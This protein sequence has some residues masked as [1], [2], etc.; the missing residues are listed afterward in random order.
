MDVILWTAVGFIMGSI[1]FS[2]IVGR[3]FL[4]TDIRRFGDHNPG[5]ANAWKA[6]GWKTGLL[7][8]LLDWL[9]GYAPLFLATSFGVE[10]W[11]LIPVA[12]APVLGHAFSPFLKFHGGKAVAASLG[13]WFGII[14]IAAIIVFAI[15]ALIAVI[16]QHENAWAVMVGTC[17]LFIYSLV[18]HIPDYFLTL[19]FLNLLMFIYKHRAELRQ[20]LEFRSWVIHLLHLR[21]S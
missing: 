17:G 21:N 7:A 12:L 20:S 10:G 19:L 1:P 16:L 9:K 14:G 18:I 11:S 4:H 5:G 6:G 13:A 3:L 2:V 8:S 15:F